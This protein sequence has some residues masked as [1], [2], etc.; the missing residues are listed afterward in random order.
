M[1]PIHPSEITPD[2]VYLSRRRFLKRVGALVASALM[3]GACGREEAA[4]TPGGSPAP[5]EARTSWGTR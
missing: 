4:P 2:H 3:L 5:G 1:I